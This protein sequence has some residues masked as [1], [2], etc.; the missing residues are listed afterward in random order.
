MAE[1]RAGKINKSRIKT[2]KVFFIGAPF[3]F[4]LLLS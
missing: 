2:D 4:F 3:R 1:E